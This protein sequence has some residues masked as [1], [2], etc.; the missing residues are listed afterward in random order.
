M[1]EQV[2]CFFLQVGISFYLTDFGEPMAFFY[3]T[4]FVEPNAFLVII[5]HCTFQG[6]ALW[7]SSVLHVGNNVQM[8]F[9]NVDYI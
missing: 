4:D 2:D 6:E 1:S 3:L 8:S 5:I 7:H 9:N